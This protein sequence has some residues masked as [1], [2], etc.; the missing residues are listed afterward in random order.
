MWIILL[1]PFIFLLAFGPTFFI[2]V[3]CFIFY[4]LTKKSQKII[5][6]ATMWGGIIA[7]I[8][9]VA[10]VIYILFIA[11]TSGDAQG[12]F[13]LANIPINGGIIAGITFVI[14]TIGSLI[15]FT[16]FKKLKVN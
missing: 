16:L 14:V 15:G 10:F 3:L 4:T 5:W 9:H 12:P 1:N 6:R 8:L 13:A 11:F 7:L 2:V